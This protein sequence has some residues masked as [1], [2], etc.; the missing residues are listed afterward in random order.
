[1]SFL[2]HRYIRF[3]ARRILQ[4]AGLILL[5]IALNFTLIH[6]APGDP[7]YL[8][9]GQSGDPQ[10]FAFIRTKFGLDQPLPLQLWHYLLNMARGDFGFSLAYQ[11]PVLKLVL[12]RMPAT[13]LLMMTALLISSTGGVLLGVEAARRRNT[14]FDRAVTAFAAVSDA[15][16][17][18][19]L[20]QAALIVFALWF[21]LFPAQGMVSAGQ[22]LTGLARV[23]DVIRHLALPAL[24][25][26]FV[27]MA[28]IVRL[29]RTQMVQV[30]DE[31]FITAAR[32]RGLSE[33]RVV[34][35]HA[36]RNALLPIITIIGTEC[37]MMLSGAVLVETV[38]AW[39]GL[40]RLM[41]DAIELRDYPVLL[42]LA[43]LVSI[44]VV[45]ANLVTDL[46]YAL[47]DPRIGGQIRFNDN[48]A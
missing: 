19:C 28:L 8:L 45:A 16:P 34:Y 47:L 2:D 20:G 13:L 22:E 1:M 43:L 17:S 27:Q 40:G 15:I 12:G 29:T 4:A 23:F 14:L 26:A 46:A 42:G 7:A 10:Y 35:K 33:S 30:L 32:A 3:I 5:L 48:P 38:F 25:L 41:I 6:L 9:A 11:Q 39:P 24:T 37:G 21:N 36:L 44:G 31:D 18:F